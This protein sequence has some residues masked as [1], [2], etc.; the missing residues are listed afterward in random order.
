MA[1]ALRVHEDPRRFAA[2]LV[3]ASRDRPEWLAAFAGELEAQV[4]TDQLRRTLAVWGL[5]G[6][7]AAGVFGVS[8]QALSKWL[9]NGIPAERLEVVATMAAATDLLVHHLKRDRIPATVRRKA[10]R[11]DGHSLLDLFA[12]RRSREALAACRAMFDW[13]SAHA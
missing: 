8:R 5:S 6:A 7:E 10:E 11:L 3:E 9:A 13:Q 1:V 2:E 12:A 4:L